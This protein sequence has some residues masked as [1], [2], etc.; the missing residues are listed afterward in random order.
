[1]NRILYKSGTAPSAPRTM[2]PLTTIRCVRSAMATKSVSA[3]LS[4]LNLLD[5]AHEE[6]RSV[7]GWPAYE[8]SN[9]GRVRRVQPALGAT[10]GAVLKASPATNGY[11]RV[12]LCD[13]RSGK[14]KY[15][16]VHDLVCRAFHG[17]PPSPEHEVAHADGNRTNNYYKNLRW[18]T[19]SENRL[20]KQL[21]HR[22]KKKLNVAQV[23]KIRWMFSVSK[24]NKEIADVFGVNKSTII[25]I[26]SGS[27]WGWL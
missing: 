27:T 10:V 16:N 6:W 14:P 23:L 7:P 9:H 13:A 26:R 2:P 17:E 18:A 22:A 19:Q 11:P 3:Q 4:F 8:V 1:M 5:R 24:N 20:D 12:T 21:H 15:R 25:R